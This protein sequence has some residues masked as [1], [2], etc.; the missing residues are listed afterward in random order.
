MFYPLP[1]ANNRAQ[2]F[3]FFFPP[4]GEGGKATKAVA[5]YALGHSCDHMWN[6]TLLSLQSH[7]RW[8]VLALKTLEL[9]SWYQYPFKFVSGLLLTFTSN[10]IV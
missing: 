8:R 1:R 2:G 5:D 7:S 6:D 9:I 10:V 3:C 4:M